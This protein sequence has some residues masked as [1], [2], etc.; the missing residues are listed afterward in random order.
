MIGK[1]QI[2]PKEALR[3]LWKFKFPKFPLL[4]AVTGGRKVTYS[5]YLLKWDTQLEIMCTLLSFFFLSKLQ[6][7][8]VHRTTVLVLCVLA[9]KGR[10]QK[11]LFVSHL[12]FLPPFSLPSFSTL[13]LSLEVMRC[14]L[15]HFCLG[16]HYWWNTSVTN[17][18]VCYR[19]VSCTQ[20]LRSILHTIEGLYV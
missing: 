8:I 6:M 13:L 12:Y 4:K 16:L 19:C 18:R 17:S 15:F 9:V 5:S 14:L 7:Y 11:T 2:I 1:Y 3:K 20:I 10:Y